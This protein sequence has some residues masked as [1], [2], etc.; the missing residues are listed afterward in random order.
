MQEIIA[1]VLQNRLTTVLGVPGIGKTTITKSVGFH[2]AERKT[3]NDGIMFFSLRGKDQTTAL[4]RMI[5]NF[6]QK[7]DPEN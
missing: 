6:L 2:L 1:C 4:M 7:H 5:F 3:F